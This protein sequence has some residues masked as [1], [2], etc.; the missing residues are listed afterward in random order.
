MTMMTP[1]D[2]SIQ[3]VTAGNGDRTVRAAAHG[4][5]AKQ[6]LYDPKNEHDAC[7]VGFI[8]HM[9]GQKSHQ[10]VKDGLFIL[11]NLTHRG[12]VGADPL[13]GDGAGILVQIPDRF[14][15]EEMARQGITLPKAG[16]YAVG[17]FF[18]PQDETQIAHFKKV[19]A[20]VCQAEG[21]ELIGYRD[22]PVDNSSLSKAPDI[23]ATEP[24][25]IQVFIGAGRDAATQEQ[26][27][28]R[29]F[30][31][32]KVISNRIYDEFRGEETGFYPVSLSSSTIVY[33]G[34]FLAFQVGA[35]YKDLAD[36]RF[37]SAVA[38]VHQRFSTNTFPSWKLAHPY[39]M[40]AHNGEINTLRGNVNWMAARQASV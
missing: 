19:I 6:G 7:G 28:R 23:A 40:V 24:R 2:E 12:A 18:F 15:R 21:Q 22:V 1:S 8:A 31:L 29:L 10:I 16:E 17:H 14:F 11:E 33:K 25:H 39:R 38:L 37:E 26:F 35:Y 30:L 20:E 27:E 9:K 3:A 13:M 4:L 34:M 32:R 36:P 5:P